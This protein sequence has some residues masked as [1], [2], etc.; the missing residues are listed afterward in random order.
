MTRVY[1][2]LLSLA[3]TLMAA[4][5]AYFSVIGLSKLFA[6]AAFS[7][8]V[9]ASALEFAKLVSAGFLY[10]YW[11]HVLPAMRAYLMFAVATL[12]LVTSMGIFGFLSNAYQK[13]SMSLKESDMKLQIMRSENDR[14]LSQVKS[15]RA[16]IEEIPPSRIS[17]KYEFQKM[18]EPE[19]KQLLKKSEELNSQMARIQISSLSD[20]A[21][22]GPIIYVA[23][24]FSMPVDKVA[25]FLILL[26]V[27]VFDPLALSMVIC[28]NLA[29]RLREKYRGNEAKI[30]AHSLMNPVVDHRF[31]RKMK[32]RSKNSSRVLRLYKTK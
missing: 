27:S 20:H 17:R 32:K 2:G 26:F 28:L 29:V 12:M 15:I 6:G 30:S 1:I 21:E 23:E 19:I 7:V 8:I 16:F 25:R 5:G 3:A 4:T 11:G 9:M 13:A 18:Y 31:R 14:V 24:T 10:R 22:L